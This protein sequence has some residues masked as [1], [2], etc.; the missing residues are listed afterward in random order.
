MYVSEQR[1]TSLEKAAVL[2]DEY[3]LT[4]K[5]RDKPRKAETVN[6][7]NSPPESSS[8]RQSDS[9][10]NSSSDVRNDIAGG[11]IWG[12]SGQFP[13]V[14]AVPLSS[15][16]DECGYVFREGVLMRKWEPRNVPDDWQAVLQTVVVVVVWFITN[17]CGAQW[18]QSERREEGE[19]EEERGGLPEHTDPLGGGGGGGGESQEQE[20]EE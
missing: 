10:Q 20:E 6:R 13:E 15:E 16:E 2:A 14:V 8:Q 9:S 1:A 17:T 5:V 18:L 11:E 7:A 4:H 19:V 3:V 12:K